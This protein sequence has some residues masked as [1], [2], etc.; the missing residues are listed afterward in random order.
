MNLR[1]FVLCFATFWAS[2]APLSFATAD[3]GY[4]RFPTLAGDQV[5]F[6]AEGDLWSVPL[7]GGRASRLTTHPG[8]ETNA[9]A[10]PDGKW[11]AFDAAYDGPVE[12]YVMPVQ[13]GLPRRIT[14]D[15]GGC[16]PVG[17]MASGEVLYS[18]QNPIGPNYQRII[19]AVDPTT[20]TRH[21]LPLADASDAAV[22]ADGHTLYFTRF[23]LAIKGDNVRLYQGGLRSQLWRFDLAG[24]DEARLLADA[25]NAQTPANDRRPMPSG[26]RV[27]F[28]SDRDG[29]ANLWSMD[30]EGG[31]RQQLTD[32]NDFEIR[33]ARLDHGRIVYQLGADLYLYDINTGQDRRLNISLVSDFEQMRR[34][35]LKNPL[36]FFENATFAPSGERVVVTARGHVALMGVGALR[37]VDVAMPAAG[38][39]RRAVLSPDG[40]WV[41]AVLAGAANVPLEP[42][43]ANAPQIW[44][45]APQIWRLAADG[46]AERQQLTPDDS[47]PRQGLVLSPDGKWLANATLD[48][49]LFV[50]DLA[51]GSNQLIDTAPSADLR[52]VVWSPDSRYIVFFRSDSDVERLQGFLYEPASRTKQR[53]TTDR[54]NSSAPAFTPDGK[55]LYF[56]SDRHFDAGSSGVW[57]DRDMG[58]FFG[59]RTQIF[60]LALQ[61]G[62]RFPFQP[63]DELTPAGGVARQDGKPADGKTKAV[64]AVD[65]PGLA[66]RLYQVP[67]DAGDYTALQTDGKRLYFLDEQGSQRHT[68]L[69]TLAIDDQ[70]A[71]PQIFMAD[72]REYA[73]SADGEKLFLRRWA[74][75]GAGDML[76]VPAGPRPPV[77]LAKATVHAG[78]WAV[79]IDP[80]E[81]WR[82]LFNDAWRLHRDYF[83]DQKM[84][85]VDWPAIRAK[86]A[87]LVERVTDRDELNDL[88]GQMS[89]ELS[90]LHSQV[91]PGDLRTASDSGKPAF[92]GAIFAREPNGAR[93]V[94]IY[95][96][97]PEIPN[98]RGPL[99]RPGV[100]VREGDLITAVNGTTVSA[101][102]DIAELLTG[103]DGQ[104]L[105]LTLTRGSPV[106]P[107]AKDQPAKDPQIE[108]REIKAVVTA[109]DFDHND[110]LRYSDWEQGR[111]NVVDSASGGRIGYLHLRAMAN[112]DIASFAREFYA[113]ID[114]DGLIIDVR[115]NNGGNIDSW[116]IEKLLRR[117]WAFW[118]S[119]YDRYHDTNMQHTFQGYVAVLIDQATYSDGESFAAGVKELHIGSL[120]GT[121]TAGA[122]VWLSD[123]HTLMADNGNLRTAENAQI[124]ARTGALLIENKGVEP[125]ITVENLPNATFKGGDAQLEAAVRF[126]LEK[127]KTDPVKRL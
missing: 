124:L 83:F 81:E 74:D 75:K 77:E 29:H 70:E 85:G 106:D 48:G 65:W 27:Y 76:I 36:D 109:V 82:Q 120:I 11:I 114:R 123:A 60:A 42:D 40:R 78:D 73:L 69:K 7:A 127:L 12:V 96:T 50:L 125:D 98:E 1:R 26:E 113:Q 62:E 19:T 105:L 122:G 93:I 87:A 72:V 25:A 6:T 88:L 92:L 59:H 101:V 110:A 84:L 20:L 58:P 79:S 23:G 104:Q 47:G 43:N 53:L 15:G 44:A 2:V 37:R 118:N 100:D 16:F 4:F 108:Y 111:R 21:A 91:R 80:R 52:D 54:Y 67:I 57:N 66:D 31:N 35:L 121:R 97:D 24:Q 95:R 117:A 94:H 90:T 51:K 68:A 102:G 17:W 126:L 63:K 8:Q 103:R 116:V 55:W 71:K 13:G 119:R 10:S 3:P 61:A 33:T 5:I 86:Y 46:S 34:H 22:A 39:A 45:N 18:G 38:R 14:F 56:L 9:V 30:Q 99:D 41:Y 112:D 64:P 32:H 49:R 115:R 107:N 89:S 28:I